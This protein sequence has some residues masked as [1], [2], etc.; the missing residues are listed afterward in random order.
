MYVPYC[1][2]KLDPI[3]GKF[4]IFQDT[5]TNVYNEMGVSAENA[6]EPVFI[7]DDSATSFG[8]T[9]FQT[10]INSASPPSKFDVPK[11]CEQN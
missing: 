11:I 2:T 5:Q 4:S 6:N 3:K 10:F 9:V 8:L 7:F 1:I